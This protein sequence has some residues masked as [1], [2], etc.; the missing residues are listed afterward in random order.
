[1]VTVSASISMNAVRSL[2]FAVLEVNSVTSTTLTILVDATQ[3]VLGMVAAT[4]PMIVARSMDIA[5]LEVDSVI[6]TTTIMI[7][8]DAAQ[9]FLGTVL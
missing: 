8:V 4:I 5:V 2:V 3:K 7:L 1:L 6:T 9:E